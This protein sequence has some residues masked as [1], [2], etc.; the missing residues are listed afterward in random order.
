GSL[1]GAFKE[2]AQP[3]QKLFESSVWSTLS[4]FDLRLPIAV[5]AESSRIGR[6]LTPPRLWEA[7]LVAPRVFLRAD[8]DARAE[9]LLRAYSDLVAEP[10]IAIA[11]IERLRPF[12][13]KERI[14]EWL[15]LAEAR[16]FRDLATALIC[17]HYDPVYERS[18]KRRDDRP[19]AEMRLDALGDV[20]LDS[21]AREIMIVAERIF[22]RE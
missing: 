6:C 7:M 8:A 18:R 1:F 17:E 10:A 14:E 20:D 12:H 9:Y 5:E 11:A 19:A 4:R 22:G 21:A 15:G 16:R 13:A 2:R 3:S